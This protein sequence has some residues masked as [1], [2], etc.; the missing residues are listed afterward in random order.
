[1]SEPTDQEAA[2]EDEL[3]RRFREALERKLA[4]RNEMHADGT[5]NQGVRETHNDKQRRQFRRKAGS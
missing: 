4:Q 1:M 3:H 2:N 5:R